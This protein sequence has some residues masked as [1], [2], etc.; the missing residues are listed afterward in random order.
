MTIDAINGS[1]RRLLVAAGVC[2]YCP[3]IQGRWIWFMH[4]ER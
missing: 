2:L 4:T 1:R 3:V